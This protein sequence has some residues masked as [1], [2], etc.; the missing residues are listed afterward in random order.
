M[1]PPSGSHMER[2]ALQRTIAVVKTA[3][4]DL[5]IC[6]YVLRWRARISVC[7]C[8]NAAASS[9]ASGGEH[10]AASLSSVS[11]LEGQRG[12]QFR[13]GDDRIPIHSSLTLTPHLAGIFP[14]PSIFCPSML[15]SFHL[16]LCSSTN[17]R[18]F[19]LSQAVSLHHH[20]FSFM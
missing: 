13:Q 3:G 20:S 12:L 7:T 18:F 19:F 2:E 6:V 11:E 9:C 8:E 4:G 14:L 5:C 15:R 10:G 1:A 17:T 16:D